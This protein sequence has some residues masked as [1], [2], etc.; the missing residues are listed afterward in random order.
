M[1]TFGHGRLTRDELVRLLTGAG[2]ESIV[3]V[4]R[5]PGS[6]NNVA[7]ARGA[8]EDLAA[9]LS[10]DYRQDARLGGRRALN[11]EQDAASPDTW[12]E[13]AAFRAYAHWTRSEE[14]RRGLAELVTAESGRRT[15]I[16]CSEAVWWRCHRRI[17]SDIVKVEYDVP[18]EHLM[19]NGRLTEH[20]VSDGART[21]DDGRLVWDDGLNA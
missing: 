6:R 11:K 14:F 8:I 3:D 4:R 18:V 1:L 19:H 21:G 13:V 20:R 12:W 9:D 17:I 16:M 2:V 7:A 10:I 15:A 5:F